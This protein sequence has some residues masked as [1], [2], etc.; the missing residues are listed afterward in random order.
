MADALDSGSSGVT[1]VWVQVPS[2]AVQKRMTTRK[3]WSFFFV[4]KSPLNP[5]V[6]GLRSAS[7]GAEPM[8]TGHRAPHLLH[9]VEK[10]LD[11]LIYKE[12]RHFFVCNLL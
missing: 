8:S 1:P 12:L 2:S 10:V 5:W 4:A 6:Q 11:S 3:G 7:V 9:W